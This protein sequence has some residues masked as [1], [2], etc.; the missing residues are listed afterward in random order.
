[1]ALGSAPQAPAGT[2]GYGLAGFAGSSA[3]ARRHV[4]SSHGGPT[5]P[6]TPFLR[7]VCG[8]DDQMRDA[9]LREALV[10]RHRVDTHAGQTLL[11]RLLTSD[12]DHQVVGARRQSLNGPNIQIDPPFFRGDTPSP[13]VERV[14]EPNRP[15]EHSAKRLDPRRVTQKPRQSAIITR[16]DAPFDPPGVAAAPATAVG[17]ITLDTAPAKHEAT[18]VDRL[19]HLR[20]PLWHPE[21]DV[22]AVRTRTEDTASA[23]LPL[24]PEH[25]DL[26]ESRPPLACAGLG[27]QHHGRPPGSDSPRARAR[28]GSGR[29][30]ARRPAARRRARAGSD[31]GHQSPTH[32][33]V[34]RLPWDTTSWMALR[35]DVRARVGPTPAVAERFSTRALKAQA[36]HQPQR[37]EPLQRIPVASP[38][39]R[40]HLGRHVKVAREH[41]A[42]AQRA[43][44]E[45]GEIREQPVNRRH[46][47][48]LVER[49]VRTDEDQAPVGLRHCQ[50]PWKSPI[51]RRRPA[52]PAVR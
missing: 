21:E 43:V 50:A 8:H 47:V 4:C 39:R 26:A 23:S 9:N 1:M 12:I 44:E 22:G 3:C 36:V 20:A 45:R 46:G 11:G 30:A 31:A 18:R 35:L 5:A 33:H 27:R 7:R 49:P 24:R 40:L 34:V 16:G 41:D 37:R 25:R 2:P 14:S 32:E 52:L 42:P 48:P 13:L 6:R 15:E 19:L 38:V 29:S 17:L 10:G 51:E 28:A